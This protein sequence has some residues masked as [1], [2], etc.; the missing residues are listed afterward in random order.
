MT[1]LENE[2]LVFEIN[3]ESENFEK[4]KVQD[5]PLYT[6]LK[7]DSIFLFVNPSNKQ[8]WMWNGRHAGVRKKFI[9][10]QSAPK[11]RDKYGIDYKI[12]A[13]DDGK[14]SIAFK[15]LLGID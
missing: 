2:F 10:A 4:I 6:I 7:P 5:E 11:V 8:I 14:E 12:T 1:E 9:A 13:V 15:V 3:T